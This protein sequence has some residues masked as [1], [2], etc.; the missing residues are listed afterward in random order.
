MKLALNDDNYVVEDIFTDRNG[1]YRR[2]IAAGKRFILHVA[3]S[4]WVIA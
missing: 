4:R 1:E 2:V 3:A